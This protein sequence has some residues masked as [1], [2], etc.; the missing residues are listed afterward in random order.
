[1]LVA[2]AVI[3]GV[4][5]WRVINLRR[6]P[7]RRSPQ[8]L[9]PYLRDD[10][11]EGR[12]L[13]RALGWSLLFALVI[14]IALPVYFIIEPTRESAAQ[15]AFHEASVERGAV[16]FSN[17][18]S[19]AYDSTKSLLCADC[20]GVDA[21]GGSAQFTLQPESDECLKKQNQGK[22]DIPQCLP[23][24]V[25]WQA[26]A[27][28]SVLSRFTRAQVTQIITYGRPGTPMPAW[29]VAS[30]K[31]VLNSQGIN[32]L[33]NYLAS[34]QLSTAQVKANSTKAIATFRKSA[35][36]T[37]ATEQKN[38]AT[39]AKNLADAQAQLAKDQAAGAN[40]DKITND[41]NALRTAQ[42][43]ADKEPAVLA[44]VQAWAAQVARMSEGEILFRLNCA[45]CHTKNW[46]FFDPTKPGQPQ[47]APQGSGAYG[48]ELSK[49][50][51]AEQF[52]GKAGRQN[53]FN[54]VAIG[55]PA[56]NLYG[57]RGISSGRM[58]HFVNTLSP[59]QI[60]EIIDYE[61]NL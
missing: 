4:L 59:K 12:R 51:L 1:N 53:Q 20:H 22:A 5:V 11:L 52:P 26:P 15:D 61:R 32:D 41:Q 2:L 60:R 34:L 13:E 46:S 30:G 16:L 17:K 31:G 56:N 14:A 9:T 7:E 19:K 25:A 42:I 21:G 8:N 54:W 23:Q 27:L 37:L 35:Q 47:P 24:Q 50:S 36:D 40:S 55:V 6:N 28:N 10:D 33:V 48:P 57:V 43:A 44:S 39:V 45:R 38:A 29:G 18:Q 3:V 58:P 49:Q